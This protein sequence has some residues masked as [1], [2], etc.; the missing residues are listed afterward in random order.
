LLER[1]VGELVDAAQ[2]TVHDL[3]RPLGAVRLVLSTLDKGYL[4]PLGEP[5]QKA[6]QNG[7][8]A[9]RL[10]ERLVRDLLES[11]RLDHDGV[12][13]E[14]ADCDL[15]ALVADVLRTLRYELEER[16]ARVEV[17]PLPCIVADAWG[18]T[19]VFL[20]LLGNA[21]AYGPAAGEPVIAIWAEDAGAE[22]RVH[23]R[24][25]GIGIPEQDRPR[26]FRRFERGSNTGG[27]SGTGLGLHIVKEIVQG[28]GGCVSFESAVGSG[29][30]FVLHL[31]KQPVQPAHSPVSETAE[32]ADL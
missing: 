14:F 20:N 19:R 5:V 25:N 31:P 1:K 21:I 24:D 9:V 23:V 29:T 26:L 30:T 16:H 28:H 12:R 17:Q 13:L 10:M 6:V 3:N 27:I 11:S 2:Q 22:W 7:L 18:L 8:A 32:R 4:G 15:A